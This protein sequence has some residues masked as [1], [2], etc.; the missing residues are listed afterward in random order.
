MNKFW[1]RS[2]GLLLVEGDFTVDN[3]VSS[4]NQALIRSLLSCL[5][6]H[7]VPLWNNKPIVNYKEI[8]NDVFVTLIK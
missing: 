2:E 8:T 6:T 1:S 4:N 5:R 7:E 3:I